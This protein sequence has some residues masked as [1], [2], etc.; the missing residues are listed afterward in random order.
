M[1][2]EAFL[3]EAAVEGFNEGI[4]DRLAGTDELQ[5]DAATIRPRVER[6]A[7]ELGPLSTTSWRGSAPRSASRSRTFSVRKVRPRVSVSPMKSIDQRCCDDDC[8]RVHHLCRWSAC[9]AT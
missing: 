6:P 9:R 8:R 2:V 1:F 4:V 3:A 5:L 7:R